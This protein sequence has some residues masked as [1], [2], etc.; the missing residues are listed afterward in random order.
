MS[1]GRKED[2][3]LVK[4]IA[5]CTHLSLTVYELQRDIGWKLQLFPT[6]AFNAPIGGVPIG[7]QGKRLVLRKLES[8]CYQTVKTVFV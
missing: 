3:T 7:I 2:S 6:L 8:W 1:H 4:R 5:A